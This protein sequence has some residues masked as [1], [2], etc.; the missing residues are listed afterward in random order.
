[1]HGKLTDISA[2][3]LLNK[4]GAG[5][6]KPGSGSASAFEGML[7]AQMLRTVIDLTNDPKRQEKYGDVLPELLRMKI[8]IESRIYPELKR[9]FELD[10]EQFDL[11]IGLREQRD[12]EQD[13]LT[14]R[15]L[16]QEEQDALQLATV[17]PIDIALLCLELGAMSIYVFDHG[18]KSARGDSGVALNTAISGVGSCLSIIDLNLITL[19]LNKRTEKIREQKAEIKVQFQTLS[20]ALSDKLAVLEKESDETR[21]YHQRIAKFKGGNLANSKT[22]ISEIEALA[23]YL[24]NDLWISRKKIWKNDTI[25]NPVDVLR[26]DQVLNRVLG[27][28][29]LQVDTLGVFNQEGESF[30]IAGIIDKSMKTVHI[31]KKFSSQTQNFTTAHELAHAILHQ[32]TILH[33]DRPID[34]I[35][36]G[37]KSLEEFQADKFAA[38]FLMP[39]SL[40]EATFHDMFQMQKFVVNESTA[41]SLTAGTLREFTRKYPGRR[42]VAR[43]LASAKIFRSKSFNSLAELFHVSIETMAIRLEELELLEV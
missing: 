30:E 39:R 13:L 22:S 2:D 31:S 27:Y 29:Y 3:E 6:H 16:S 43:L 19:P 40:V 17:T 36:V 20:A 24:Q 37:E 21:I 5:N 18:F 8:E 9:L 33:R 1:M 23:R 28:A 41:F 35:R 15:E 34:G 25:Q 10:S 4:F 7:S 12:K 32:Q 42:E 26:P 38:F 11:V 14:K